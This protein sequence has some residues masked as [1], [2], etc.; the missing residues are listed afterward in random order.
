MQ[1]KYLDAQTA[2]Q[3]STD[4]AADIPETEI[5][6]PLGYVP[7]IRAQNTGGSNTIT[8]T[9]FARLRQLNASGN[10]E[11]SAWVQVGGGDDVA[12]GKQVILDFAN[13]SPMVGAVKVQVEATTPGSQSTVAVSGAVRPIGRITPAKQVSEP[14]SFTCFGAQSAAQASVD[15][16]TDIEETEI[17]ITDRQGAVALLFNTGADDVTVTWEAQYVQGSAL[18][19]WFS[20]PTT[21]AIVI[22]ADEHQIFDLRVM[23][24]TAARMKCLIKSTVTSTPGSILAYGAAIHEAYLPDSLSTAYDPTS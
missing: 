6:V 17:P 3:T 19:G 12:P 10:V 7:Q 9:P 15:A 22:G 24:P 1:T 2:D 13:A 11:L 23:A 16:V 4:A 21:S 5:N 14:Y 18:S 8:V 20:V